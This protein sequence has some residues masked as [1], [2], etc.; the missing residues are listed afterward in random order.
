MDFSGVKAITI[1]QGDVKML[2]INGT[3]MWQVEATPTY[4]NQVPISTDTDGSIFNS[5]GYK[6]NVRLSSSGSISGSAQSGSVTTGFIPWN[7]DTTYLRMKGV[8]W[9]NSSAN[10]G[11]HS[12]LIPYDA[13]KKSLGVYLSAGEYSGGNFNHIVT[14]TRDTNGVETVKF[15]ETYGTSN[16]TL[17]GFRNAKF[18]RINA[19]GKG[20][21]FVVT[22]N[23]EIE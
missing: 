21:D 23:E 3:L 17:Q 1:P 13:S 5:V 10:Y 8:E 4:T 15:S 18:I 16:S 9:K 7:G 20:A 14:V 12:Y 22:I 19:Y 11:G 2:H 6:E